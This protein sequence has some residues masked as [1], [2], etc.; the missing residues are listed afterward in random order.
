MR[1]LSFVMVS[2][3][4]ATASA[5]PTPPVSFEVI[6]LM[7]E[8]Q[9]ALVFD[10]GHNTHVL[11]APGSTF[12]DFT[13]VEISGVG[14]TLQKQQE[15]LVVHPRAAKGLALDLE[16]RKNAP[17]AIYSKTTPAAPDPVAVAPVSTPKAPQVAAPKAVVTTDKKTSVGTDLASLLTTNSKPRIAGPSPAAKLKP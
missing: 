15:R 3:L 8:T 2:L 16:P 17:P 11:L 1:L 14:L 12:D 13:V 5:D 4:A 6:R 9:Q 10:R 7:P